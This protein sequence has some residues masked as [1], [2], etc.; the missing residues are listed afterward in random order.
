MKYRG[1]SASRS[2]AVQAARQQAR[3]GFTLPGTPPAN[4]PPVTV[5]DWRLEQDEHGALVAVHTPS[6]TRHTVATPPQP[7]Q[8]LPDNSAGG[9]DDF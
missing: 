7:E 9:E 5:G 4:P 6:G 1:P 3:A 2:P 8:A